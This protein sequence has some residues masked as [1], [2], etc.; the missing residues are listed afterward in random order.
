MYKSHLQ[1]TEELKKYSSP[2]SKITKMINSKEIIQ[3]KRGIFLDANDTSYSRNSL[4]SVIY[5]PSYISFES[6][7]SYHGL[8]PERVTAVTCASYNK[9]KNKEFHT[10][11]GDFY[12]FYIPPKVFPYDTIIREE[13]KQN[14]IIASPEK[15]ICDSLYRVKD[16]KTDDDLMRLLIEDWRMDFDRLK[17]L[18]KKSFKF[19]LPL[20][21][22]KTCSLFRK[23]IAGF[24]HA[25]R[26]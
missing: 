5:G 1:L 13:N 22:K 19:L 21:E 14:F 17:E 18:E 2:K 6:A 26:S 7:M 4:S 25:Q 9:N 15:A 23:W 11:I 8:I 20:Y 10:S 24:N 12:Y 3:V 16:I